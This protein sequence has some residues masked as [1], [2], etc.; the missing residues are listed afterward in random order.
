MIYINNEIDFYFYKKELEYFIL[1]QKNIIQNEWIKRKIKLLYRELYNNNI[2]TDSINIEGTMETYTINEMVIGDSFNYRYCF[3][4]DIIKSR[5][6]HCKRVS[7]G[8]DLKNNKV[9]CNKKEV[10]FVTY[11]NNQLKASYN[12]LDNILIIDNLTSTNK[13]IVID[14]NH[15]VNYLLKNKYVN[16]DAYYVPIQELYLSMRTNFEVFMTVFLYDI[17]E[18]YYKEQ[19]GYNARRILRETSIY[20]NIFDEIIYQR[21]KVIR[22]LDKCSYKK[23]KLNNK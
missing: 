7:L 13:Y 10:E 21:K 14:G 2:L 3:I 6:S 8:L 18:M 5:L 11:S 9:Y 16:I 12:K 23:F 20:K 15:R 1:E 22:T 4:I 17:S 19:Y